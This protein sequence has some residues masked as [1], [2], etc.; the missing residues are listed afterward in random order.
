[1]TGSRFNIF[2]ACGTKDHTN[3]RDKMKFAWWLEL[4]IDTKLKKGVHQAINVNIWHSMNGSADTDQWMTD[5]D[6]L[7]TMYKHSG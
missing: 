7:A 6:L 3:Q 2:K 4:R 5:T 1:M